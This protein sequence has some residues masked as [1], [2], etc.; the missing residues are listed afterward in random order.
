MN[1]NSPE[2]MQQGEITKAPLQAP[3]DTHCVFITEISGTPTVAEIGSDQYNELLKTQRAYLV[4]N[5]EYCNNI[6]QDIVDTINSVD[7]YS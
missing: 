4:G 2:Q 5:K 7:R 1:Q 6:A 3:P